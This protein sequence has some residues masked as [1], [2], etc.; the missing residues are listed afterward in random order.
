VG[1]HHLPAASGAPLAFF[2]ENEVFQGPAGTLRTVNGSVTDD[3]P[4]NAGWLGTDTPSAV[5]DGGLFFTDC[6]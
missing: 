1:C 4:P 3:Q 5:A 6:C 2:S